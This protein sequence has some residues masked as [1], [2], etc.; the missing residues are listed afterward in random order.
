MRHRKYTFKIGRTSEHRKALL[1]NQV[2]SFII[3]GEIRT[4]LVKARQTSR[5]AEKMVTYAKKGDLHHRRLAIAKIRDVAAVAKLFSEIA[6][7]YTERSGGYTRIIK[8]GKRIGDAAEMCLLQWV[9][10][11]LAPKAKKSRP[12]R[13]K[14]GEKKAKPAPAAA[15]EDSAPAAEVSKDETK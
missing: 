8:L 4:T 13:K 3:A 15:K 9:E 14:T 2:S 11:E 6:P 10:E 7:K 5:L 1:G 12:S